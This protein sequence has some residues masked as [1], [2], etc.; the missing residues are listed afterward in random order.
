MYDVT[1]ELLLNGKATR[2]R[3]LS[4][5]GP[6]SF[7][8]AL[9]LLRNDGEFR[10]YLTELLNQSTYTAFRWETPHLQTTTRSDDFEFVLLD[11]P[12]FTKR[13]TDTETYKSYFAPTHDENGIVSFANLSGDATLIVPSP[14]TS[15]DA[16]G[17]FAT[18]LR[19]APE[20]QIDAMWQK[21]GEVVHRMVS[22][23]P[24]WLSTAGG[25]VAWLHVRVDSTPKYYGYA[26][27][28]NAK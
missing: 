6:V 4:N 5:G 16:Y 11:N 19:N 22:D 21:I 20:L 15:E 13:K 23:R 1:T 17:H 24:I 26:P 25:G 28:R 14:R 27:Y 18:F 7:G 8:K 10:S 9:D 2:Y 12:S 3:V